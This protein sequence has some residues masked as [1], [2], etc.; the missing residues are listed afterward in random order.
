MADAKPSVEQQSCEKFETR[1]W[2]NNL[3][4]TGLFSEFFKYK[5]ANQNTI[6]DTNAFS[7]QFIEDLLNILEITTMKT[8]IFSLLFHKPN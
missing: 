6:E 8:S 3:E 2:S 5:Y 4:F 7:L 1:L